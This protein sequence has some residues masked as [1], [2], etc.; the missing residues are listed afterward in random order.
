MP[1]EV[2]LKLPSKAGS[3]KQKMRKSPKCAFSFT[4]L[5]IPCEK[6]AK[7]GPLRGTPLLPVKNPKKIPSKK[8]VS[9]GQ[10]LGRQLLHFE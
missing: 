3:K 2:G 5:K 1:S 4:L 6:R 9:L 10:K 7:K 8:K